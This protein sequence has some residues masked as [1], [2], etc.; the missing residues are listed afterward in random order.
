MD[1]TGRSPLQLYTSSRLET[2]SLVTQ[3]EE[4]S[5]VVDEDGPRLINNDFEQINIP[6]LSVDIPDYI[7]EELE[8]I[9]PLQDSDDNGVD[10]Y[11]SVVNLFD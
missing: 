7:Q 6:P 11:L 4:S 2:L 5:Y 3:V 1:S 9:D 8:E 10:I